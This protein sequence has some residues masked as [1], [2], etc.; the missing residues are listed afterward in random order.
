MDD[1]SPKKT[2]KSIVQKMLGDDSWEQLPK[3]LQDHHQ[4]AA[5]MEVGSLEIKYPKYMQPILTGLRLI[6]VLINKQA[7][8]T[9]T[10][11][12]KWIENDVLSWQRTIKFKDN[13]IVKFNS[14]WVYVDSNEIIEYVNRFLG[15]KMQAR[16]ENKK[17]IFE[18]KS[19]V[20]RFGGF[21][22][23]VPE[24]L[25]LGHTI[26]EEKEVDSEH[27]A[28][29]FC[30]IHPL[31]GETFKYAGKFKTMLTPHQSTPLGTSAGVR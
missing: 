4:Y 31:F 19:Y 12:K 6:G 23:S 29:D 26:I 9:E 24:W 25:L 22:L 3:I 16:V 11:V 17:L 13:K 2:P 30:L 7:K 14:T 20:L 18:G 27:Y 10:T 28:M 8:N 5:T 1:S 21:N 15:L